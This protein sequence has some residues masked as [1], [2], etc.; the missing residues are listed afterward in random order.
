MDEIRA[1][2]LIP[3]KALGCLDTEENENFLKLM[4]EDNEF[5]WQEFGQYQ[6][7][8]AQMPTLLKLEAPDPEVK[9]KVINVIQAQAEEV[10][11]EEEVVTEDTQDLTETAEDLND[12]VEV[13]E[14][15]ALII[16]EEEI[17]PPELEDEIEL[18]D[19]KP[20][21]IS[22][23]SIKEPEK[24]AFDLTERKN[25]KPKLTKEQKQKAQKK[26]VEK[27]VHDKTSKNHVSKFQ[28][29]EK[30]GSIGSNK[31]LVVAAIVIVI[32]LVFLL[33]MYLGLTSEIDDNKQE[34]QKLKQRIGI[35]LIQKESTPLESTIV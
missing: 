3:A 18:D 33:I 14:D 35:A 29:E 30:V 17:I 8:V 28:K 15:E 26:E 32:I 11:V 21:V 7:L 31:L 27:K 12:T 10:Q 9:N 23:I 6:N 13:I 16:E 19:K 20:A 5:P 1:K 25:A 34:I 2:E 24:P 4:E 22:G